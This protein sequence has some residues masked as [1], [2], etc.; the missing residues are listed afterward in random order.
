VNSLPIISMI[1]TVL[2][3]LFGYY[4]FVIRHNEDIRERERKRDNEIRDQFAAQDKKLELWGFKVDTLWTG[5]EQKLSQ[6]YKSPTHL[7]K[8]VLLDKL[9]DNCISLEEIKTLRT[10][11]YEEYHVRPDAGLALFISMLEVRIAIG[12]KDFPSVCKEEPNHA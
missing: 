4:S 11:L 1:L 5:L 6:L 7:S 10:M 12:N 9:H 8:D 3:L 2:G